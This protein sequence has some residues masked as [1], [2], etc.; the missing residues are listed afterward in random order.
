MTFL[1]TTAAPADWDTSAEESLFLGSA[2]QWLDAIGCRDHSTLIALLAS[3]VDDSWFLDRNRQTLYQALLNVSLELSKPGVTVRIGAVFAEAERLSGEPSWVRPLVSA[4][5][6]SVDRLDLD[7]FHAETL[8]RWH[9][10]L[11][12]RGV[13]DLIGRVDKAFMLPPNQERFDAID[14][15][16]CEAI[17]RWRAEPELQATG[18]GP[19]DKFLADI[20]VPRPQESFIPTGLAC[21]DDALGGGLS[22][23]GASTPGRV[24][25]VAAR[26]GQGKTLLTGTLATQVAGA[27]HGVL[28][29]SMEMGVEQMVARL[30]A[31]RHL[32]QSGWQA[33]HPF[34]ASEHVTYND[35]ITRNFRRLTPAAYDRIFDGGHQIVQDNLSILTNAYKPEA[36][37]QRMRLHKQRHPDLRLVIVDHLGLLDIKGDNRAV[38]VGEASRIIKTTAVELGVDVLLVSQ[39]NRGVENRENKMPGMAD[40]RDSGCVEQD[41]D[42]ILGLLRPAYYNPQAD[43]R[44][45]Q[46][47]ILKNR[48]GHCGLMQTTVVLDCCAVLD[49]TN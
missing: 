3:G 25:V 44:E 4:L 15:Q 11:A 48:Q 21:L 6:D 27:G 36:L 29:F 13:R 22:G 20:Q 30:T 12:A 42:M 31:A 45:L 40:L 34:M 2:I 43:P 49:G 37:A 17:D 32:L 23:P 26:P 41:A 1:A 10:K 35:L 9:K 16:L 18:L 19:F 39:L 8:P 14:R 46:I 5:C 7:R 24:I 33:G 38:A 47:G 28:L